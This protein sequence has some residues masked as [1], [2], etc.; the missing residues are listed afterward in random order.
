MK[1]HWEDIY[2]TKEPD[3]VSWTQ[4]KPTTSLDFIRSFDLPKTAKI[5]DVGGGDSRLVDFLLDEGYQNLTVLDISENALKR[6]KARLGDK[7]NSVTWIVS[8][9]KEFEPTEKYDFW[10]DRAAFH[11]LTTENEVKK[12]VTIISDAVDGYLTIGTFSEK[13]PLKCSGLPIRQYSEQTLNQEVSSSFDKIRCQTED[14]ITPFGT[15]QNF[16]FCSFKKRKPS[17]S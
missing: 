12:Y 2:A 4:E 14:H 6:A 10:H 8:D 7:A 17:I 15:T 11:F 16:I 9:I 13:G 1:S 5:I 3:Q